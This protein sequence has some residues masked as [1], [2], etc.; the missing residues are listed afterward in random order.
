MHRRDFLTRTG[1]VVSASFAGLTLSGNAT[2]GG[3]TYDWSSDTDADAFGRRLDGQLSAIRGQRTPVID[4]AARGEG[5][6]DG[7]V[8]NVCASMGMAA[9]FRDLPPEA[10]KHPEMQKRMRGEAHRLGQEVL[11]AARYLRSLGRERRRAIRAALNDDPH[12]RAYVAERMRAR[13]PNGTEPER[14]EQLNDTIDH[15]MW[16]MKNQ[17]PDLLIDEAVGHVERTAADVGLEPHEW[18]AAIDDDGIADS[19]SGDGSGEDVM[20]APESRGHKTARVGLVMLA[21]GGSL[22]LFGT[23]AIALDSGT[24]VGVALGLVSITVGVLV[25]AA[26]IVVLLVAAARLTMEYQDEQQAAPPIAPPTT[27][28]PNPPAPRPAPAEA[29]PATVRTDGKYQGALGGIAVTITFGTNGLAVGTWATDGAPTIRG[30]NW[31]TSGDRVVFNLTGVGTDLLFQAVPTATGL[32][33]MWQSG[34]DSGRTQFT[35]APAN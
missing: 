20:P 18:D 19:Y 27:P 1:A 17:D 28:P 11:R 34:G 31:T 26:A 22:G 21:I 15:V 35:F 33:A 29:A 24:F 7:W 2:A 30:G 5:L 23:L 12:L 3:V 9:V 6:P 4:Q 16:R 10:Q 8:P 25:L 14:V 13:A 32:D